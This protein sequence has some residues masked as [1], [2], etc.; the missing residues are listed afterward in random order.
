A[1]AEDAGVSFGGEAANILL[2]FL[3][4]TYDG[5]GESLESGANPLAG[6]NSGFLIRG[7]AWY[8][9]GLSYG[10]GV[11]VM[12]MSD[13]LTFGVTLKFMQA[14]AYSELLRVE[15]MTS[16]GIEDTLSRLGEKISDAY[17]LEA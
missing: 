1:W 13:W 5:T 12:G 17:S 2:D 8:E 4:N 3:I 14:Y 9:L 15:D 7:L 11:P 16:N 10:A 6:N